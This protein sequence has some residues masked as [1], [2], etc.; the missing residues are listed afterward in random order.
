MRTLLSF[1]NP[2]ELERWQTLDDVVMGGRSTSSVGWLPGA[3]SGDVS[4]KGALRYEGHVSLENNG[5]FSSLRREGHWNLAGVDG[6]VLYVRGDGHHYDFRVG[7]EDIQSGASFRHPFE[8]KVGK[9]QRFEFAFDDFRLWRRGQMLSAE[10]KIDVRR[11][12]LFGFLIAGKQAGDFRLD[13]GWMSGF[14]RN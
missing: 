14:T 4:L 1:E 11:I 10:A 2:D 13:V 12:S 9:W 6:I 8:T 3:E 5:G 7:T